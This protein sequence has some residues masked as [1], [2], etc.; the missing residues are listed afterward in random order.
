MYP[1]D[2]RVEHILRVHSRVPITVRGQSLRVERTRNRP[3]G[4][5][6]GLSAESPSELGKPLDPETSTAVVEELKRTVPGWKGTYEASRVLWIGRLPT[7]I[8]RTALANFWSRLGCVVEVRPCTCRAFPSSLKMRLIEPHFH[9]GSATSGF[10][11]V[12]FASTEDALRAARQGA[13]YGFRYADRLLDI[14]FAP[15]ISYFGPAYCVVHIS[16]WPAS[17]T[18]PALLQWAYDLPDIVGAAVRASPLFFL[19]SP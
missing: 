2:D 18:R 3:Y 10:A 12:E 11:H 17:H 9:C 14:D 5:E 19:P 7:N 1:S 4:L 6:R 8:S 13:P 16:G 15:W